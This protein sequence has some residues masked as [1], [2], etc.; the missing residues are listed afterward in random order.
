MTKSTSGDRVSLA[1]LQAVHWVGG[2]LL[3][4][5]DLI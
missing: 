1:L 3:P 4:G 2:P 5:S